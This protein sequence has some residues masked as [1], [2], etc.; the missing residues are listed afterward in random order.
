MESII[1]FP[2]PNLAEDDGLVAVGGEL[3]AEYLLSAYSQGLFPWFNEGEPILWWS[4]NPRMILYPRKFIFRKS[5]LQRK[6]NAEFSFRMDTAFKKV[7]NNCAQVNRKDQKGTWI[8]PDMI[9]AYCSLHELGYAHCVE[10]YQEDRL[11]G[12]LYGISLGK[13]FF[14][15]SMFYHVRDAS[16]LALAVLCEKL[17]EWDYHFIDV[18]QSTPH[19][20]S[21]GAEDMERSKFL[22]MLQEALTYSS[23]KGKWRIEHQ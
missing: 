5:L 20:R 22:I 19:L 15:E 6:R 14:G 3:S 8:S 17:A 16:K 23:R 7:M 10:T 1:Q 21:L 4:P 13:V 12:G 11:V 2:D 9:N 18:Q